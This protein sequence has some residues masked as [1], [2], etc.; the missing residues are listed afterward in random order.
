MACNALGHGLLSGKGCKGE[1]FG[2]R[3]KEVK[4]LGVAYHMKWNITNPLWVSCV[5]RV[6]KKRCMAGYGIV[7]TRMYYKYQSNER[8]TTLAIFLI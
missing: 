2:R 7:T 5:E 1:L 6:I 3:L 4:M 8:H